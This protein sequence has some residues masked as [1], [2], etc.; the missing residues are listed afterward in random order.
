VGSPYCS[1]TT[2]VSEI[3]SNFHRWQIKTCITRIVGGQ[4]A[5]E[6]F[7]SLHRSEV[8]L[9]PQFKRLQI[10]TVKGEK[11]RF[12]PPPPGSLSPVPYGGMFHRRRVVPTLTAI[13]LR[14]FRAAMA[15]QRLQEPLLQWGNLWIQ[16]TWRLPD[17]NAH[18]FRVTT[19]YRGSFAGS[20][21]KYS[22]LKPNDA[23]QLALR[24]PKKWSIKWRKW[25]PLVYL[26]CCWMCL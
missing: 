11:E 22:S 15:Q 26:D 1:R 17:P 19:A 2:S 16:I 12:R 6:I 23:R 4:D 20:A 14:V 18:L 8:L 7:Y 10:G 3:P 9:R 25:H 21:T 24:S 5:T 13:L